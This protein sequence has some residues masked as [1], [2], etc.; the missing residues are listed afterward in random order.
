VITYV[1]GD[2]TR[3]I[4]FG[5]KIIAHICNDGGD[6]GAGFVMALANR[7]PVAKRAYLSWAK[8]SSYGTLPLG[9]VQFVPVSDGVWVANMIGQ[10]KEP[11]LSSVP[12]V[13]Y[14]AV[15]EALGTVAQ[16][17]A[18]LDAS[19]HM[20]RIGTGLAG[21]EWNRIAR[22]IH[23]TLLRS[24]ISTYVYDLRPR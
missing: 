17:A 1:E 12:P 13:R 22:I 19:V 10:V 9:T 4:G 20:P 8:Q 14:Y 5:P 18:S 3:P 7:Y 6:W 16:R 15:E 23:D 11:A 2:A 24:D 21:G